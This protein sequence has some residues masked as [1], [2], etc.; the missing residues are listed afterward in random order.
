MPSAQ[1]RG[2]AVEKVHPGPEVLR[3]P[4]LADPLPIVGEPPSGQNAK[5]LSGLIHGEPVDAPLA[6]PTLLGRELF[7]ASTDQLVYQEDQ[8]A[9]SFEL[10]ER[11]PVSAPRIQAAIGDLESTL[12]EMNGPPSRSSSSTDCSR[13]RRPPDASIGSDLRT[14]A[15][16]CWGKVQGSIPN[17]Q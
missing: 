10:A 9:R 8:L 2:D 14:I 5:L 12:T 3:L 16:L 4:V 13:A 1:C 17:G 6:W 7:R 11:D 15:V